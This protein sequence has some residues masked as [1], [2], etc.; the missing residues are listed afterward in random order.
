MNC[1]VAEKGGYPVNVVSAPLHE[2]LHPNSDAL[3]GISQHYNDI[4]SRISPI[5]IRSTLL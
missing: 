1:E 2:Y 5:S 3:L 4:K